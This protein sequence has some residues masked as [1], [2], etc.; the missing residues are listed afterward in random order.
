MS[1]ETTRN[2]RTGAWILWV[3]LLLIPFTRVDAEVAMQSTDSGNGPVSVLSTRI[4]IEDDEPIGSAWQALSGSTG[5]T[6]LNG[7]GDQ[8]GDGEPSIVLHPET[9]EAIAAWAKP[10]PGSYDIVLSR[11][12]SGAWTAPEVLAGSS[13]DELDPYLV[14]DPTDGSVHLLY[15]IHDA[16]PRVMH[17]QSPADLSSWSAA[18]QVSLPGEIAVRP[19]AAFAQGSLKVVYERHDLGYGSTPRQIVLA[20]KVGSSF[21]TESV[22][23]SYEI[24]ESWPEFHARGGRLWIDWIHGQDTMAWTACGPAG[25]EATQFEAFSGTEDRVFRVRSRIRVQA[26][27]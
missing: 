2:L 22:G 11:T 25:W 10:G 15:W 20:T 21:S 19:A 13:A 7:D 17:R 4:I 6:V 5:D 23:V 26:L 12:S 24:A 3:V 16:G 14:I 9:G 8:N 18:V 27:E 1:T